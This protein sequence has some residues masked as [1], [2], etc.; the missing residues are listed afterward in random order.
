MG[1]LPKFDYRFPIC[2]TGGCSCLGCLSQLLCLVRGFRKVRLNDI[3][4]VERAITA[5]T[6]A[7]ILEPIQGEAGVFVASDAFL[8]DLRALTK[9]HGIL[10][11]LDE[12]QTGIGRTG[13]LF[14]FQHAGVEPD[15]MVL[16]K[17]LGGG[18][19][20]GALVAHKDA[21]CFAHGDQGGTFNG[22]AFATA[23]GCAVL[24]EIAKPGFLAGVV[25]AGAHL[26]KRLT[27]LSQQYQCAEVRGRGL[28]LA[29]NLQ[30][31]IGPQV[32]GLAL[33]RGLLI[34]APR[35]DTLRFM[36]ALTV[37]RQEI[38][39]M[40]AILGEVLKE[41]S[42]ATECGFGRRPAETIPQLLRIHA[43]IA[44][45]PGPRRLRSAR[46]AGTSAWPGSRCGRAI[47]ISTGSRRR[48]RPTTRPGRGCT[49]RTSR[50]G[51]SA[52]TSTPSFLASCTTS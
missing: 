43:E 39:R 17:G 36:P 29:L 8:R 4:Q 27:E 13:T 1:L 25:E 6:V 40:I 7:V 30:S 32:V 22:N 34:N 19:P 38:D 47:S 21:C 46:C 9:R 12:I 26:A 42:I 18:I 5:N 41:F 28:L 44:A 45:F 3:E 48:R 10:L 15:V 51:C 52:A 35:T 49:I 23:V 33:Q 20:L 2:K 14:A 11:I 31:E 24:E 50:C 16:A 37:T